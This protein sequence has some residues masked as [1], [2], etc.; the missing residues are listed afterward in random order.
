MAINT[1][2]P[3]DA[4][5]TLPAGVKPMG[6]ENKCPNWLCKGAVSK[7]NKMDNLFFCDVCK[8]Y[9]TKCE[10][11]F[12]PDGAKE[13]CNAY[14]RINCVYCRWCGFKKPKVE[15]FYK[16]KK[17]EDY[18]DKVKKTIL[19]LKENIEIRLPRMPEGEHLLNDC[20]KIGQFLFCATESGPG[21]LIDPVTGKSENL[22]F[23]SNFGE[24][25][26]FFDTDAF[27]IAWSPSHITALTKNAG[28]SFVDYIQN[29]KK[30]TAKIPIDKG[31]SIVSQPIVIQIGDIKNGSNKKSSVVVCLIECKNE[32]QI[33]L[34]MVDIKSKEK[35]T[36]F[37]DEIKGLDFDSYHKD[38]TKVIIKIVKNDE[39]FCFCILARNK[40]WISKPL[41]DFASADPN[42][43]FFHS[44]PT[45]AGLEIDISG[46]FIA[47]PREFYKVESLT[48]EQP[49]AGCYLQCDVKESGITNTIYQARI[50]PRNKTVKFLKVF[51]TGKL[52]IAAQRGEMLLYK[53]KEHQLIY[54]KNQ[55]NK[56]EFKIG[57]IESN[58]F[59]F[60]DD[61]GNLFVN[62]AQTSIRPCYLYSKDESFFTLKSQDE[63]SPLEE[64]DITVVSI[65]SEPD[66][67]TQ[68]P[69]VWEGML[70]V[71][72]K[73]NGS[74]TLG[75]YE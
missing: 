15:L 1:K 33:K 58:D 64:M 22:N 69:V 14:N 72:R 49:V 44:G 62:M 25:V 35:T 41:R 71:I 46:T 26:R 38:D 74:L 11:N 75:F 37:V 42:K 65:P 12:G 43:N 48:N 7:S 18:K 16:R 9:C 2:L 31:S 36:I 51:D 23:T 55:F 66:A 30:L 60:F 8:N 27:L 21:Y 73:T 29:I 10:K 68:I 70:A 50:N 34:L 6:P 32:E 20:M 40:Y 17:Q 59:C 13:N 3:R 19:K 45:P 56:I 5:N 47:D 61:S 39:G 4:V 28:L 67:R 57:V 54:K 53:N 52:K 24:R 63:A